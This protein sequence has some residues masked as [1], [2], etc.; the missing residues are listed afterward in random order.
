MAFDR[1]ANYLLEGTRKVFQSYI[2]L[3]KW[4]QCNTG[5][6]WYLGEVAQH[7][8]HRSQPAPT[9]RLLT[10]SMSQDDP[11]GPLSDW[12]EKP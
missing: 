2:L 4:T 1:I 3:N 7:D 11:E 9:A 10:I 8:Q 12:E 6:V 5:E